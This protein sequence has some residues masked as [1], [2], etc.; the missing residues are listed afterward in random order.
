MSSHM[1]SYGRYTVEEI[2]PLIGPD[3]DKVLF[4]TSKGDF[5]VKVSSP[6]LQ[7]FQRSQQCVR[8]CRSGNVFSLETHKTEGVRIKHNCFIDNCPW[9]MKRPRHFQIP[10]PPHLNFYHQDIKGRLF[11]MTQDHIL[12][13]SAGGSNELRNLQTM[14]SQCNAFKAAMLPSE[15]EK[16]MFAHERDLYLR[17]MA[18]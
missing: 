16:V 4:E 3:A 8:C 6:R 2:L 15:Y 9:C 1:I 18:G 14:C 10:D 12:P 5:L 11:L 17:R 7:C 13:K